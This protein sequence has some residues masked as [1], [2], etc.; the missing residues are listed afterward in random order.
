MATLVDLRGIES[1]E[2]LVPS[3][4]YLQFR[5]DGDLN[6]CLRIFNLSSIGAALT[7]V[8]VKV[9]W[10]ADNSSAGLALCVPE[11]TNY[12]QTGA[13]GI[14]YDRLVGGNAFYTCRGGKYAALVL[15]NRNADNALCTIRR[16]QAIM[17][18]LEM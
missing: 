1:Y 9:G 6:Y 7:T 2:G 3:A 18:G 4:D 16:V 12:N 14:G 13:A 15:K 5:L 11:P 8:E 17:F 10:T